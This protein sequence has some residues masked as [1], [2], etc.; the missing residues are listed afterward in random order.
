MSDAL[1]QWSDLSALIWICLYN[2]SL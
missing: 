1:K 2:L